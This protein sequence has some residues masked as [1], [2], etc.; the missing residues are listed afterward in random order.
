[1]GYVLLAPYNDSMHLGQGFN[2]FLQRPCMD[3]AVE[4]SQSNTQTQAARAGGSANISQV[5]SYSS[6]FVEKISDVVRSMNI[7]AAS[8]IK[9]GTIEVSGNSLSVDESKF[10]ASDM[11]AV[12]S[13]KV[14]NRFMEGGD[15][16]GIVSMKI[17][18]TSKRSSIE[19]A[20]KGAMNGASGEFTLSEGTATSTIDA[21]VRETESTITVNWSGGG[22]IKHD[23]DEWTLDS[24][25]RAASAFPGRVAACPQK[26]YAI[27][28]PYTR[29]RSFVQ[30]AED[31][32]ITV[33]DFSPVQHY[34]HDLLDNFMEFKSNLGRLQAAIADPLAY[35]PSPFNNAV[36]V[37]IEALVAERKAIKLHMAKIV[38]IIGKLN[39]NPA[40]VITDEVT[41]PEVWATRL[42]VLI[43]A[44]LSD[45][46]LTEKETVAVI[47]GF[48][49]ND[50]TQGIIEP[51]SSASDKM[52]D[53]MKSVQEEVD[54]HKKEVEQMAPPAEICSEDIKKH[55][56]EEELAFVSA[57]DNKRAYSQYRFDRSVGNP[58]AGFF[59]DAVTL[60]KTMVPV[61]WPQSIE[62][63]LRTWGD[64]GK[65]RKVRTS[66]ERTTQ[67]HGTDQG[68][69]QDSLIVPLSSG[70]VINRIRLG[71][72]DNVVGVFGVGFVELH[73]SK[74][75][76]RT[77]G[78]EKICTEVIDCRPYDGCTG[79][80]GFWGGKGD[81]I[82]RL[83]PIW[84]K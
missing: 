34:T 11:N 63:S 51:P 79:L 31:N 73:T 4:I 83:G 7:S 39:K 9:L 72:G 25:I 57:D 76:K 35:K 65:I 78:D 3:G 21:A 43:D 81:I 69:L 84:G 44:P 37:N 62:L 68:P 40:E 66:Y 60:E 41:A 27:L 59:V 52:K 58:G 30:W 50:P 24:L 38:D 28:T 33:P 12:I 48:S 47:N 53:T 55:L 67:T 14:V 10:A 64:Y 15:L 17:L 2:S 18:D 49:D 36:N 77:I 16:H 13:V 45:T 80:K 70:E 54:A 29:N 23:D 26:T 56:V 5:V 42:P 74:G 19:T 1:M 46:K 22:Q 8:S 75:D 20:L 61:E 82:D 32:N 71:K 6:R